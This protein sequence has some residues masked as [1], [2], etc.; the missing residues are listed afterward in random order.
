[1]PPQRR[2]HRGCQPEKQNC[3]SQLL[4]SQKFHHLSYSGLTAN[5][6]PKILSSLRKIKPFE[7][8]RSVDSPGS[9]TP[10]ALLADSYMSFL[11]AAG[12][13]RYVPEMSH[14]ILSSFANMAS[15]THSLLQNHFFSPTPLNS[16]HHSSTHLFTL[17]K[18]HLSCLALHVF[19]PL[20]EGLAKLSWKAVGKKFLKIKGRREQRQMCWFLSTIFQQTVLNTS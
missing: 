18:N 5:K 4:L 6:T 17:S 20:R 1:M 13:Q 7:A 14:V 10:Q 9:C 15:L 12:T 3:I 2:N 19:P 11:Q 16:F 8:V